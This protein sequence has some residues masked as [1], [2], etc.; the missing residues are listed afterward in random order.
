[1]I[2][3]VPHAPGRNQVHENVVLTS[4]FPCAAF[5]GSGQLDP[6]FPGLTP[7]ALLRH[8]FGVFASVKCL[9]LKGRG[10]TA[11]GASPGLRSGDFK[12]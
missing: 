11:Q 7:W 2:N 1:M 5:Q 3:A 12:P 9:A 6:L 4:R 8:P 10:R